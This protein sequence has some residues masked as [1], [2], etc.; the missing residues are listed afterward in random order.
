MGAVRV[1]P[2]QPS[3]THYREVKK[4]LIFQ[5]ILNLVRMNEN[6]KN[7]FITTNYTR[8]KCIII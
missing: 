1:V 3:E 5:R 7:P 4:I 2:L 6:T 8:E